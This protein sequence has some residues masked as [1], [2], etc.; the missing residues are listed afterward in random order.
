MADVEPR[1]ALVTGANRGMGYETVRQLARLGMRV[2]LSGRDPSRVRQA[3]AQL[4]AEG[5]SVD[6]AVMDVTV[7]AQVRTAVDAAVQR[8]GRIDVLVNNAGVLLESGT[9]SV[10]QAD[11]APLMRTYDVNVMG[12]LRLSQAV[13]PVMRRNGYGRIVN[14][15]SGMGQLAEMNGHWPG[16]RMS[17]TALNA[18]TR[19][20]ADELGPGNVKVNAVCPGWVRTAMGG[21]GA[22][23]TVEE[24][25]ATTVW[26][27]CLPNDGPSGGFFR[28]RAPIPW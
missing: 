26:L 14:V 3:V 21:P 25:V 4:E 15:S 17:K 24:G 11:P 6:W 1:V 28:D 20:L 22:D 27:A 9:A 8:Y 16:Y 10:W 23:R 13:V 5:Q 7:A 2:I 18:L 12:A 19:I